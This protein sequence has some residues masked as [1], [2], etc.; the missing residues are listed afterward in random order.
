MENYQ[1]YF[2]NGEYL[3][4]QMFSKRFFGESYEK[5]HI[6]SYRYSEKDDFYM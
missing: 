5:L 3:A 2:E 4:M 6:K 1:K